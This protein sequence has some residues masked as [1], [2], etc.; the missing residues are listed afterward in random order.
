MPAR[1][2][3]KATASNSPFLLIVEDD[4]DLAFGLESYF[5]YKRYQVETVSEGHEALDAIRATNP[6]V[7]LL[8]WRLPGKTGTEVLRDTRKDGIDAPALMLSVHPEDELKRKT[9]D[10]KADD[11][12]TK[13]FDLEDLERRVDALLK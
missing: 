8:D 9:G 5:S 7:I 10:P 13:P 3:R 2:S 1:D 4:K 11:Y 12:L 6:D